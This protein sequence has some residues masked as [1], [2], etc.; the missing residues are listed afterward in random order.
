MY[1]VRFLFWNVE[2]RIEDPLTYLYVIN[3]YLFLSSGSIM[4][5]E[6]EKLKFIIVH[7][8]FM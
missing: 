3:E 8:P 1:V 6:I 7:C 2:I 5:V 4:I